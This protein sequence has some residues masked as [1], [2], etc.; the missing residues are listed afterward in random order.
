[1]AV[2]GVAIVVDWV[3]MVVCGS[4]EVVWDALLGG[5]VER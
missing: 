2:G 5:G 3:A 4:R 1:M